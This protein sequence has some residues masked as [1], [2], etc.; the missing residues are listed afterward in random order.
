[1]RARGLRSPSAC[2]VPANRSRPDKNFCRPTQKRNNS[3]PTCTDSQKKIQLTLICRADCCRVAL[4]IRFVGL[5]IGPYEPWCEPK[6]R[7]KLFW[8]TVY[9]ACV[10]RKR[11]SLHDTV[12]RHGSKFQLTSAS[13]RQLPRWRQVNDRQGKICALASDIAAACNHLWAATKLFQQ[14][15][16][17]QE[18]TLHCFLLENR[19]RCA[20]YSAADKWWLLGTHNTLIT[21]I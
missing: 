12:Q 19:S 5:Q 11:N 3:R 8:F 6:N 15:P 14:S 2:L 13:G 1:M 9:I 4:L 7:S 20:R 18:R 16:A 17:V 21:P 10:A